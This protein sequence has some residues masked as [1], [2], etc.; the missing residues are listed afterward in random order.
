[1]KYF[2]TFCFMLLIGAALSAVFILRVTAEDKQ[3]PGTLKF[4]M[5]T[6]TASEVC[7]RCHVS[8]YREFAFGF[9]S[10]MKY[11]EMILVSKKEQ[12][13]T[14]PAEVSPSATAH[15]YAGVEPYPGHARTTEEEGRSCNVCHFPQAYDIPDMN[16]PEIPKP[17]GRAKEQELGGLTCASCH[18]NPDGKKYIDYTFK[19]EIAGRI[20]LWSKAD[21][22]AF[23]DNYIVEQK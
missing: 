11:K 21:S 23:F 22:Y 4:P 10:D 7:G 12:P 17:K 6:S 14:I 20:G 3:Q 9:G 1:M 16:N 8:I 13:L 5:G 15:V 18:L 19:E 2:K